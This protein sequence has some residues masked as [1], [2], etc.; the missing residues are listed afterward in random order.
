MSGTAR[1][2]KASTGRYSRESMDAMLAEGRIVIPTAWACRVIKRYLDEMPGVPLQDV[3]TDIRPSLRGRTSA[4]GTQPRSRTRCSSADYRASSNPGD[5]VADLFC[6]SGTTL[7]AAER[8]GR[9]WIGCDLGRFAIHTTRKRLLD[10]PGLQAVRDQEP[11]RVRAPALAGRHRQRRAPRLPRHDPRLLPR[12]SRRRLRPPPRAQGRPHGPRRRHRRA[13]DDRRDRGR[14]G[15]DGRQRHRVVRHPR[16]GVGDGPPRHD[17]RA[18]APARARRAP[19]PDPARGHGA[20][21]HGGGRGAVL[22]AR[23]RR[24]RRA[25]PRGR[26]V[27]RAEG[28]RDPERGADPAEGPRA[29]RV[30]GGPHR[31]LVRRLRLQRRGLSQPVAGLPDARDAGAAHAERLAR[32]PRTG[33]ATRSS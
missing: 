16:L 18:G 17:H 19:A 2:L 7:V 32:V 22:R 24:S 10:V 28:L 15:R 6:G 25:A 9:R 13:G 29:D 3:W 4:S 14:H 1:A 31:L 20:P 11:R 5:L 21:G 23:A 33:H 26:G 12:R 27:R 8:L 30:V